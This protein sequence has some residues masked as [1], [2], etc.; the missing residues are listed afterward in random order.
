VVPLPGMR[1]DGC[2]TVLIRGSTMTGVGRSPVGISLE[3]PLIM[4]VTDEFAACVWKVSCA[5]ITRWVCSTHNFSRIRLCFALLALTAAHATAHCLTRNN[6]YAR[7]A[8][9]QGRSFC[10]EKLFRA[11]ATSSC[12][13]SSPLPRALPLPLP[14]T[15]LA[16]A[17]AVV[18]VVEARGS[19]AK[20]RARGASWLGLGPA[21]PADGFVQHIM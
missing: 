4:S 14:L 10:R 9:C 15:V 20:G 1:S 18:L 13:S 2:Y 7:T 6:R 19:S 17:R 8:S 21:P 11:P 5:A 12:A 3:Q 16:A